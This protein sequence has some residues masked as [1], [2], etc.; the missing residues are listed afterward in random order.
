MSNAAASPNLSTVDSV[1]RTSNQII[2]HFSGPSLL[3]HAPYC[4]A[5]TALTLSYLVPY[6]LPHFRCISHGLQLPLPYIAYPTL[7]LS[8]NDPNYLLDL[9]ICVRNLPIPTSL[10]SWWV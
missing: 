10:Q 3:L 6:K 8:L 4:V 5:L 2:V 9:L 7:L 1:C